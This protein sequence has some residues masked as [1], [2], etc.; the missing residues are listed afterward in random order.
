MSPPH[1]TTKRKIWDFLRNQQDMALEHK[2]VQINEEEC[3]QLLEKYFEDLYIVGRC[4][5]ILRAISQEDLR[6]VLL[7]CFSHPSRA[8]VA[9][10]MWML[11]DYVQ[12]EDIPLLI[13]T[14]I[15]QHRMDKQTTIF[16]L[17]KLDDERLI[18]PVL[19]YVKKTVSDKERTNYGGHKVFDK[20]SMEKSSEVVASLN[21]LW[22]YKESHK[23]IKK[24]FENIRKKWWKHLWYDEQEWLQKKSPEQFSDLV[25]SN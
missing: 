24:L 21:F 11:R 18:E 22:E 3:R 20:K 5:Y 4:L 15:G 16:T 2:P 23:D 7:K 13:S 8:I 14:F 25:L 9:L 10:A 17:T 19:K 1:L 6:P 12:P